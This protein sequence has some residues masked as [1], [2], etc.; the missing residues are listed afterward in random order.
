MRYV[1][2]KDLQPGM[3]ISS[4]LYDNNEKIL[5]KANTQLT[6]YF[7]NRISRLQF[8]GVYIF[9][10]DDVAK[11]RQIVSDETRM[12]AINKLKRLDIN[13]CIFLANDIVNEIRSSKSLIIEQM[14]L[15][16]YDSY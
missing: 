16:S 3:V 5:L 4:N 10:K 6:E 15:S 2:S 9:E 1:S 14:S 13:A 7:I 8:D 12:K 11:A